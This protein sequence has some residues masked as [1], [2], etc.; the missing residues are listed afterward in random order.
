[1]TPEEQQREMLRN[2]DQTEQ[3]LRGNLAAPGPDGTARA[4]MEIALAHTREAASAFKS[5]HGRT[6]MEV[7]QEHDVFARRLHLVLQRSVRQFCPDERKAGETKPTGQAPADAAAMTEPTRRQQL[8][9][10]EK[11]EDGLRTNLHMHCVGETVRAHME[12]GLSHVH[13]SYIAVNG[14][15]RA[16]TVHQLVE[17]L[18]KVELLFNKLRHRSQQGVV[19]TKI[20]V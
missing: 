5:G 7:V 20:R 11:A 4:H 2:L 16:R 9:N 14:A 13:E 17:H 3:V 10:L 19:S 8:D 6:V 1:M 12:R 15:G 18:E